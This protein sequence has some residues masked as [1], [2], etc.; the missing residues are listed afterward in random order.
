ML[1]TGVYLETEWLYY[2]NC[3]SLA[4][5]LPDFDNKCYFVWHTALTEAVYIQEQMW[6]L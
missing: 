2:L 4:K 1:H 5:S 6:T 3:L